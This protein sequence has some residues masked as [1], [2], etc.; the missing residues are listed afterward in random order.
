[1]PQLRQSRPIGGLSQPDFGLELGQT[2][3]RTLSS[4]DPLQRWVLSQDFSRDRWFFSIDF[5][6]PCERRDDFIRT[7]LSALTFLRC[8]FGLYFLDGTRAS[9]TFPEGTEIRLQDIKSH[10]DGPD[11]V[12]FKRS[13]LAHHLA[14]VP[15]FAAPAGN[16]CVPDRFALKRW[17]KVR[18]HTRGN[19]VLPIFQRERFAGSR[20]RQ[21][22]AN[23]KSGNNR[24]T[25]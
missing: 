9:G 6:Q 8:D 25:M 22:S 24:A 11:L 21:L 1:M 16:F 3:A 2:A 23:V 20:L 14:F 7:D 10:P 17:R 19:R 5:A 13:L 18:R 4:E 15:G 12:R